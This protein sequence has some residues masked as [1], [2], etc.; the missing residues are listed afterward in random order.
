[1]GFVGSLFGGGTNPGMEFQA[2]GPGANLG[3]AEGEF[4]SA[5]QNANGAQGM[6]Y[7]TAT[8]QG[9]NVAGTQMANAL[10]NVQKAQAATQAAQRGASANPALLARQA[11]Y[12]SAAAGA[13][14]AGQSAQL[15]QE[16]MVQGQ[17]NYA[18]YLGNQENAALSNQGQQLGLQSNANSANMSM[19]QQIAGNQAGMFGGVM[20]AIGGGLASLLAKGGMVKAAPRRMAA[21][22]E[23]AINISPSAGRS[24]Q[25]SL[26]QFVRG[27]GGGGSNSSDSLKQGFGS[28]GGAFAKK[29]AASGSGGIGG[30]FNWGNF[31]Y[32]APGADVSTLPAATDVGTALSD[33]ISAA[34]PAAVM[35]AKSGGRV[36]GHAAV[37]GDSYKNDTVPALLSPKEIVIPRHI[38]MSKNAPDKA[39]KFVA[40]V[41]AR[42]RAK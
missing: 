21:G 19:N 42:G 10:G 4:Q 29:G 30:N 14:A 20:N 22:G 12:A 38:T 41:L 25:S 24:E 35:G 37:K 31:G 8:G 36:P 9:P 32:G 5:F 17:S 11:G 1:M 33:A 40:A 27:E 2:T 6:L 3:Q 26:G 13:Q 34:G 7:N 16:Q 15:A 23:V 39:K 28:F 18:N